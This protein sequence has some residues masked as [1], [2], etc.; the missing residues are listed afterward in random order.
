MHYPRVL[1]TGSDGLIGQALQRKL[2][3]WREADVL[4]TSLEPTPRFQGGSGGYVSLDV[5]DHKAVERVFQDFSPS[6]VVHLA[7][8]SKVEACED[9]KEACWRVNV[10]ATAN[11][12]RLCKY[13][14]AR[15]VFL[16]TDFIF[17][18]AIGPY[19]ENDYPAPINS[20]GRS[21]QA[22]ENAI[23]LSGLNQWANVR[24]SLVFGTGDD[25]KRLNLTTLL[26]REL[27]AGRTFRAAFDQFRS[28]TYVPDLADGIQRIIRFEKEGTFHL[29]GRERMSVLELC[30]EAASTFG[31]DAEQIV[32][33]TTAELHPDAPRPLNVGLLIL[34]AESELRFRPRPLLK[35]FRDLGQRLGLPVVV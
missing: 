21:K 33:A 14:G 8:M 27:K 26:V 35:S 13:H 11:L 22:A 9:D 31:F 17:D 4:A 24:T 30:K 19:A 23:R 34:R 10:D 28:P 1:I 2:A 15:L 3:Q 18:G 32:S 12:A 20:Y 6:A 5:T 7:A 29:A 25:L 16:S